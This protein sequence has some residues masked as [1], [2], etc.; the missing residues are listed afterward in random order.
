MWGASTYIT[1]L[2]QR[3]PDP[4]ETLARWQQAK[5]A[6]SRKI[7]ELGGTISHQHG[8]GLDHRVYLSAEKE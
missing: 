4:D 6:A 8:V 1:Y 5:S 2:Y 7:V 3:S